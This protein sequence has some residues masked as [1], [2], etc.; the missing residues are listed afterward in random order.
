MTDAA[1]AQ[2]RPVFG[3]VRVPTGPSGRMGVTASGPRQGAPSGA[4][5][6]RSCIICGGTKAKVVFREPKGEV[7]RCTGCRHVY[8]ACDA[9]Q[10]YDGYFRD[11]PT[12]WNDLFW[13]DQARHRMYDDFCRRFVAGRSGRL[14]DVGC[15]LGF[16]LKKMREFGSWE[17]FGC[18]I[19][20]EG[21]GYARDTLG[22]P[23]I[24]NGRLEDGPFKERS[25]DLVTLWDVLEH[26]PDPD[27]LLSRIGELLAP[28]GALFV[29]TPN[30]TLQIYKA[31]VKRLL[32]GLRPDVHYL[33]AGAHLNI[34]SAATLALLLRRNGFGGIQ[35]LHLQPVQGVSGKR[36]VALGALRSV[37]SNTASGLFRMSG[38]R[39]NLDNLYSLATLQ[40]TRE[41]QANHYA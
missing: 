20:P 10:D 34:Y 40:S 11:E 36:G 5:R 19:S 35:F 17:A 12:D 29:H 22:L 37:W 9:P 23:N 13:W 7:L 27:P 39:L 4:N 2:F 25:F 18:E 31:R 38:S 16:F 15:G 1:N 21:A 28:K 30:A 14:L 24:F 32:W 26:I 3:R 6:M 41:P 33:E 8:S